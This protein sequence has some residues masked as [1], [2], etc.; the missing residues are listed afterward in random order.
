MVVAAKRNLEEG[1]AVDS[2]GP[3]ALQAESLGDQKAQRM[4]TEAQ[5]L[6]IQRETGL[7]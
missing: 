6:N 5:L 3:G 2:G 4:H 1:G 7:W